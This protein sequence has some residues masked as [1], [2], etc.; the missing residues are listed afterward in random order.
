[1]YANLIF[2]ITFFEKFI[3]IVGFVSFLFWAFAIAS[4][5]FYIYNR[6]EYTSS[7]YF[8]DDD[9]KDTKTKRN[10]ANARWIIL[11]C[12]AIFTSTVAVLS[13]NKEQIITYV[14]ASEVDKYNSQ[15]KDSMLSSQNIIGIA[16][17]T[18]KSLE[19]IIT[20]VADILKNKAKDVV[21]ETVENKK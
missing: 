11:L 2:W 9:D 6:F 5:I 21:T 19:D 18:A 20:S 13:P 8:G 17:S 3:S 7:E 4:F 16:D 14:V 10:K 1:M 15:Q 12:V